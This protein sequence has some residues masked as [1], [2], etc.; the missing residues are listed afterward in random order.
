VLRDLYLL[1]FDKDLSFG[2]RTMLDPAAQT[3]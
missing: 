1:K 3:S 2:E